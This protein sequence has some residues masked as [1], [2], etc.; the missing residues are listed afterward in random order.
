MSLIQIVRIVAVAVAV[1]GAFVAIPE[2]GLI[3]AIIGLVIGAIGVLEMKNKVNV[4]SIQKKFVKHGIWLRPF[5]NLIYIMPP[6]IISKKDLNFL[7]K[8]L[9][10]VINLE[11]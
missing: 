9:E 1:I 8:Q 6:Y 2:A 11:Y 7:L 3:M 4:G 10:K 5:S